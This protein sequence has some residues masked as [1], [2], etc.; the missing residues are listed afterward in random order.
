MENLKWIKINGLDFTPKKMGDLI[1]YEGA[2]LSHFQDSAKTNEHYFFRWVDND[3][4]SNRWLIFKVSREDL[5]HFFNKELYEFDLIAKNN[6]ITFL[7]LD[8]NLNKLG[9]YVSA[10]EDVPN[11]YLPSKKAFFETNRYESYALKLKNTLESSF[12]E[13]ILVKQLL[14]KFQNLDKEEKEPEKIVSEIQKLLKLFDSK[15]FQT[16][17]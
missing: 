6:V 15:K 14:N 9:I 13:E 4:N 2:L 8:D 5:I 11:D 16:S 1:Y 17:E 7:D 10:F 12:Q 3:E